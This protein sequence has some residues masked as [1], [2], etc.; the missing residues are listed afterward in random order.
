[1]KQRIPTLD[2]FINENLNEAKISKSDIEEYTKI[3]PQVEK[4]MKEGDPEMAAFILRDLKVV[5]EAG[6]RSMANA[7]S[8][9]GG[10]NNDIIGLVKDIDKYI[11][12][13]SK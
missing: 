2:E 10:H 11:K 3:L 6:L 5:Q 9:E 13:S 7:I 8:K 12:K 4:Y 1:M